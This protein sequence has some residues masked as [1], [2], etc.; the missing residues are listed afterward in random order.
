MRLSNRNK[1]SVF[2]FMNTLLIMFLAGGT[3]AY[4]LEE[5]RFNIL[6]KESLLLIAIPLFL[7][8][9]FYLNGRQIFEYDSEGE[10]LHFRN[11]NIIPFLQKPL[12]DEFPKYKLLKFEVINMFFMKRLYIT[13]S[14]K[15]TGTTMLKYEISYLTKK[16]LADLRFSLNKVI[17]TN[18]EKSVNR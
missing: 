14:S 4:F 17:K 2:S 8:I 18:K 15:N 6:G 13:I 5:R 10:A 9:L 1:T 7:I 3:G 11:R 16:E 12:S